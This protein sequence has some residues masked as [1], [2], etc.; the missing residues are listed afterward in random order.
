MQRW[1]STVLC[2][3]TASCPFVSKGQLSYM[4]CPPVLI[5]YQIWAGQKKLHLDQCHTSVCRLHCI[6][7]PTIRELPRS[8][9]SHLD[10]PVVCSK[11]ITSSLIIFVSVLLVIKLKYVQESLDQ[12][13]FE[14][15]KTRRN[16][17]WD[18][19]GD[20]LILDASTTAPVPRCYCPEV[21]M[22]LTWEELPIWCALG[23]LG[24]H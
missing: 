13:N 1:Q 4:M 19:A 5:N 23:A 11:T 21:K 9:E 20:H 24:T 2:F 3:I 14:N 10:P 6:S 7:R 17:M 22:Q 16:I 18:R 15:I 8:D 12:F